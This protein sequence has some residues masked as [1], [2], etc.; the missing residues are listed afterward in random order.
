MLIFYNL[1]NINEL[2]INYPDIYFTPE[3][4]KACEYSDD[5]VWELC[6][7]RDLIY[8]YLKKTIECENNIYYDLITPY[9]YTGYFYENQNTYDEFIPLFRVEAKNRNYITE[10]LRQNPYLDSRLIKSILSEFLPWENL[11]PVL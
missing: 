6:K 11:P 4:G 1:H 3:Y 9:G 10:V 7:F 8:V 2:N 5:A